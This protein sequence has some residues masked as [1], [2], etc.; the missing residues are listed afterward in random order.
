MAAKFFFALLF[1]GL[2]N[3]TQGLSCGKDRTRFS[4]K[5]STSHFYEC[6]YL[7]SASCKQFV[8]VY[9]SGGSTK[10]PELKK[11]PDSEVYHIKRKVPLPAV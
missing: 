6:K 8:L 1:L 2:A 4:S 7:S 5:V 9:I 10:I 11:C 3:V